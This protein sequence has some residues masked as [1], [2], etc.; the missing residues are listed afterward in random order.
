[1]SEPTQRDHPVRFEWG[2][3]GGAAVAAG[4][5]AVVVVDVLSFTTTVTVAVERGVQVIPYPLHEPA[6][7][8]VAASHGAALAVPRGGSGLSLSPASVLDAGELPARLVLPSPN[9][10]TVAARLAAET[11]RVVAGSLRNASTVAAFLDDVEEIAVV[12]A[13]ERWP[14]GS[15]RPAIEDLW[16]AGAIL[17]ALEDAGADLS[18]EATVAADAYRL[19]E[20]R[21][22]GHLAASTSGIELISAGHSRDV[23][24]A[25]ELD[26][27]SVVPV[28]GVDGFTA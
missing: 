15:L 13:G 12:A 23:D 2:P 24:L 20:G 9:G 19:V 10:S 22:A 8:T 21:L 6:A 7:E 17:A 27:S 14:D 16:G 4:A 26:A 1:M 5:G 28:L 25:A 3:T 11:T 18:P